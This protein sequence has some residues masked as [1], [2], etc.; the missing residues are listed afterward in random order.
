MNFV[1][2]PLF[3]SA[4]YA[5]ARD[6]HHG[7]F[8]SFLASFLT[9]MGWEFVIEYNERVSINDVIVTPLAGV[10]IGEFAHKLG[11]YLANPTHPSH[12]RKALSWVLSPNTQ[13][14]E[15]RCDGEPRRQFRTDSL[16]YSSGLWHD[17]ALD[18]TFLR[19]HRSGEGNLLVHQIGMSGRLKSLRNY[20]EPG[21]YSYWF[22]NADVSRLSLSLDTSTRATGV[23]LFTDTT[24]AGYAHQS[25]TEVG[26]GH[27]HSVG[28]ALGYGYENSFA[29]GM[30]DRRSWVGFPGAAT[31]LF[32]SSGWASSE[33][34]LRA[35][36]VFGGVSAVAFAPYRDRVLAEHPKAQ[37]KTILQRE[38]Y[39]YGWGFVG[40]L[41]AHQ[42]L[43]RL[44]SDVSLR[45]ESLWSAEGYDREQA[46]VTN[47]TAVRDLQTR[48]SLRVWYPL[49]SS[50]VA[51]IE[52]SNL[53]R[54]SRAANVRRVTRQQGLGLWIGARF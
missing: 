33:F 32:W 17:F 28:V 18:Y 39:I 31:D 27:A 50:F 47:D 16:G 29:R 4:V 49:V 38:G 2:H 1:L 9:S 3:G 45:A 12:A 52:S 51:G 8:G 40:E 10:T 48:L 44:H 34:E 13:I 30:D 54:D 15:L 14:S 11:Y 36:P 43:G 19:S 7:V 26:A 24:I 53:W 46:K 6:S 25:L 23:R 35:Y 41:A 22:S 37:F 42:R 20:R 21:Q 5:I